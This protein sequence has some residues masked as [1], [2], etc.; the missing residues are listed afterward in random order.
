FEHV[1]CTH[2]ERHFDL[3][4]Q[5]ALDDDS[6]EG[7]IARVAHDEDFR[8]RASIAVASLPGMLVGGVRLEQATFFLVLAPEIVAVEIAAVDGFLHFDWLTSG[9]ENG[10]RMRRACG[11]QSI[12]ANFCSER[13]GNTRLHQFCQNGVS[14]SSSA[15]PEGLT[16]SSPRKDSES[17][18]RRMASSSTRLPCSGSR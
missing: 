13:C 5:E 8:D 14:S 10:D 18:K 17:M 16:P 15:K 3:A 4:A 6:F 2:S 9:L 12:R 11:L 7:Q 1:L